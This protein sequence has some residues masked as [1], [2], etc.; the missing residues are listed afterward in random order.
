[1]KVRRLMKTPV[2]RCRA[3][4]RTFARGSTSNSAR[5]T[6]APC[7]VSGR[8]KSASMSA[9]AAQSKRVRIEFYSQIINQKAMTSRRFVMVLATQVTV[10]KFSLDHTMVV[11]CGYST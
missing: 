2:V 5:W 9:Q 10:V 3:E 4:R 6:V 11:K 1:M 7:T 8:V